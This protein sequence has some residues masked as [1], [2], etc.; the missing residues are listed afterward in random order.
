VLFYHGETFVHERKHVRGLPFG[1]P[2]KAGRA[3]T[4]GGQNVKA[5]IV[6]VWFFMGGSDALKPT[7]RN[8]GGERRVGKG[9]RDRNELVT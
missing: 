2:E 7:A 6:T 9:G 8:R 3:V 4:V 5:L 1:I